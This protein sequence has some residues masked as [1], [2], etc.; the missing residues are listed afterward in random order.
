M[1]RFSKSQGLLSLALLLQLLIFLQLLLTTCYH[2]LDRLSCLD[3]CSTNQLARQMGCRTHRCI[4]QSVQFQPVADLLSISKMADVIEAIRIFLHR[5]LQESSLLR[6]WL[7]LYAYGTCCYHMHRVAQ[8]KFIVTQVGV[9]PMPLLQ[10][11]NAC[12][13][14]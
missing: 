10:T 3:S 14:P 13:L 9:S 2:A 12:F 11:R 1:R 8:Y 7:Q 6:S 4:G 5:L